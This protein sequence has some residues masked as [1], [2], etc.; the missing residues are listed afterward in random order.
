MYMDDQTLRKV[1]L[2]Q[3]DIAKEIKRVCEKIGIHY[4]L[5]SGTLLGAVRHGGFIPWDDDLDIGMLRDDYELFLSKA[6]SVLN[7]EYFL[8]TCDT[9][10]NYGLMFAKIRKNG[11]L[12][13]EEASEKSGAHNGIYVDVFPYDV[14]PDDIKKQKYQKYQLF[15]IRRALL[16]KCGY[17]PWIMSSSS[18]KNKLF[19]SMIYK[20][21]WLVF[22]PISRIALIKK[23]HKIAM[24]YNS[25][26]ATYFYKQDGATDYGEWLV[27]QSCFASFTKLKFED[28]EFDCPIEYEKYLTEIYGNYLELPPVEERHN[29]HHILK[30]EL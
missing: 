28:D 4:F 21:I 18:K 6:P 26:N 11:T 5:D 16:I 20:V 14:Y 9:D 17:K 8:Q 7:D 15:I 30:V 23:Y 1:Q 25:I 24:Q 3:L 2:A 22:L 12:F 10:A 13:I 19:K 27:S 29:R